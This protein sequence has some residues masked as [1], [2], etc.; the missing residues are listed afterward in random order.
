[1]PSYLTGQLL[2][3]SGPEIYVIDG[4]QR[5]WIPNPQT[6]VLNGYNWNAVQTVPDAVLAQIPIGPQIDVFSRVTFPAAADQAL[7]P[8]ARNVAIVT[9]GTALYGRWRSDAGGRT[10]YTRCEMNLQTGHVNGVTV[11]ENAVM[12]TGYHSGT[13]VLVVDSNQIPIAQMPLFRVGVDP[14]GFSSQ[15]VIATNAW[16]WDVGA[17]V[18]SQA[19]GF[20]AV[21]SDA[22]D[23]IQQ[24]MNK[25]MGSVVTPLLPAITAI[26]GLFGGKATTASGGS[27]GTKNPA[28]SP[29]VTTSPAA[30][31]A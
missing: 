2:K 21:V 28:G 30:A 29:G 25:V 4:P 20:Y 8:N 11:T 26:G 17:Q 19:A 18:A 22:P 31:L 5:R 3:G 14:K 12:F 13:T 23:G 16:S 10:V 1:M 7:P 9:Y 6:F 27:G 15:S 24:I